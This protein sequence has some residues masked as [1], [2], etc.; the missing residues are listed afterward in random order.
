MVEASDG[1]VGGPRFRLPHLVRGNGL[2]G[3][4]ARFNVCEVAK[5]FA[6]EGRGLDPS[7][8]E[9]REDS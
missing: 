2:Y 6:G 7:D 9:S 3:A 5:R 1:V 8:D 4:W